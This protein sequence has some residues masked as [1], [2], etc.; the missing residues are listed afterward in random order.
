M[1]IQT[2]ILPALLFAS[3]AQGADSIA[4]RY[5]GRVATGR[6]NETRSIDVTVMQVD[7]HYKL[8][9]TAGYSTGRSVAPDFDGECKEIT[10]PPYRFDFTDSFGN[11]GIATVTPIKSGLQFTITMTTVKDS[12]CLP[13]YDLTKLKK[14]NG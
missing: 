4:G 1:N 2:L 12:R 8:S 7:R 14:K 13:L 10:K 3:N 9:G 6:D 5:A 11:L